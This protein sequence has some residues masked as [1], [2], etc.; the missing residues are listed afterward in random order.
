MKPMSKGVGDRNSEQCSP[1]RE[2]RAEMARGV[3]GPDDGDLGAA[4]VD[5]LEDILHWE[6][7]SERSMR[8]AQK[9]S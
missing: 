2:R 5:A 3:A 8:A 6:R 1:E 9:A 4:M 7:A